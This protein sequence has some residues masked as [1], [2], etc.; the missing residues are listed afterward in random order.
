MCEN[1]QRLTPHADVVEQN[2]DF[3][4]PRYHSRLPAN[5]LPL[6]TVVVK[7]CTV[8]RGKFDDDDD[9]LC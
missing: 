9:S 4:Y 3:L 1:P 8:V 5:S 6:K 2:A 7:Y